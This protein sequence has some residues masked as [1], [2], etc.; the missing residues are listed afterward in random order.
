M[1]ITADL[2]DFTAGHRSMATHSGTGRPMW[3]PGESTVTSSPE[4][5]AHGRL[6]GIGT[7]CAAMLL[8]PVV[9]AIP[10]FFSRHYSAIEVVS[11]SSTAGSTPGPASAWSSWASSGRGLG[12]R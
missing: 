12:S 3:R 10:T 7:M 9:E 6:A 8:W 5:G 1:T 4:R 2:E 11:R